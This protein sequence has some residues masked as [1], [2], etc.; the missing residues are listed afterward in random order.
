MP[1]RAELE[2][3]A[4]AL[5]FDATT[6]TNDSKL[7]QKLLYLEKNA[8]AFTGA[9]AVGTL[10]SDA[11]NV[12]NNDT[13]TIGSQTYTFKTA[14]TAATTAN[15]VLIGA[16]AAT[17]LD[18]LKEAI[19]GTGTPGTN[20]GSQTPVHSQVTAT[21]NTDTTQ[22]VAARDYAVGNASIATT[23]TSSHLSWGATTLASGTSGVSAKTS[24]NLRGVSGDKNVTT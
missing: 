18:Y 14:L 11:T 17:S 3:R 21:T 16:D 7:E 5:G 2:V 9:L 4:A 22:V 12:S 6:I 23:E 8:T 15:Q 24:Y 13:V 10:T 19:N 20:Y 1:S